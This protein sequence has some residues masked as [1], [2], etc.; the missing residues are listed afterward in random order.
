MRIRIESNYNAAF[1][2]SELKTDHLNFTVDDGGFDQI[3]SNIYNKDSSLYKYDYDSVILLLNIDFLSEILIFS[4]PFGCDIKKE[5]K[6]ID[7]EV[8]K[9]LSLVD[10]Y[11]R[12]KPNTPVCI[13]TF[14]NP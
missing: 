9:I 4:D 8:K 2:K 12:V 6:K 3:N 1:V 7:L 13:S 11:H 5:Y 10:T 14:A